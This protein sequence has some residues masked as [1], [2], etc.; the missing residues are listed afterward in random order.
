MPQQPE[1][2]NFH[3]GS[4]GRQ[5]LAVG[6]EPENG[7]VMA[8]PL[9]HHASVDARRLVVVACEQL[10]KR[11]RLSGH[12]DRTAAGRP[13]GNP[14]RWHA[15]I[16]RPH[17]GYSPTKEVLSM[18]ATIQLLAQVDVPGGILLWGV[19]S[20]LA[21]ILILAVPRV[22]NYVVAAYLIVIG[23]LQIIAGL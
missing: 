9:N 12:H 15:R 19:I 1:S 8:G 23:I 22:L 18:T 14:V 20:L 11:A 5:D 16:M 21:G 4:R 3:V 10:G 13:A 2:R 6:L 7:A 17:A